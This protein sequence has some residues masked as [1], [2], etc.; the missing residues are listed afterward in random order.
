MVMKKIA[1]NKQKVGARLELSGWYRAATGPKR[2]SIAGPLA[3]PTTVLTLGTENPAVGCLCLCA[4]PL[5][6]DYRHLTA[7][8]YDMSQEHSPFAITGVTCSA[9]SRSH[10]CLP[11]E[12]RHFSLKVKDFTWF[13]HPRSDGDGRHRCGRAAPTLDND[14]ASWKR[15]PSGDVGRRDAGYRESSDNDGHYLR[16]H[17]TSLR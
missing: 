13:R 8:A 17:L 11:R 14:D 15:A 1:T 6:P 10:P 9:W 3:T 4:V 7:M 2:R 5:F 16:S 12:S